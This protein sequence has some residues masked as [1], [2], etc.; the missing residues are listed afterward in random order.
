[1]GAPQAEIN[2]ELPRR[3]QYRTHSLRCDKSLELKQVDKAGF[4]DLSLGHWRR[5]AKDRFTGKEDSAFWHGMDITGEPQ[6]CQEINEVFGKVVTAIAQPIKF[7]GSERK[8]FQELKNLFK[9]CCDKKVAIW[10]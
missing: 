4:Y 10:R 6:I 9:A 7:I 2:Q 5:D 3:S 8:A 1:M